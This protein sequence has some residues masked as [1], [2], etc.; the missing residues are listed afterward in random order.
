MP[1][2]MPTPMPAD[3]ADF[4]FNY[5]QV[6]NWKNI[7]QWIRQTWKGKMEPVETN[8]SYAQGMNWVEAKIAVLSATCFILLLMLVIPWLR[9]F[10]HLA[11]E[12]K[13]KNSGDG[14][15]DTTNTVVS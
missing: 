11:K 7:R 3:C 12:P 14:V 5:E 4:D 9:S 8:A 10:I 15:L 1:T 6:F 13:H 2:P